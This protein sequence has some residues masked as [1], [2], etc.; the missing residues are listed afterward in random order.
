MLKIFES[1]VASKKNLKADFNRLLKKKFV[2]N[3]DTYTFLDPFA[4]EFE[5]AN[6]K[7]IFSG[8]ASDKELINGVVNSIKELAQELGLLAG[9][10]DNSTAWSARYSKAIDDYLVKL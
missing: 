7:I 8:K 10:K 6:D 1:T 9:L 3:A 2:E 5:Y 4:G